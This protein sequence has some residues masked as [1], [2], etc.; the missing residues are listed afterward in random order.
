MLKKHKKYTKPRKKFDLERVKEENEIVKRY[1]LKNKREVW[2]ADAE[3]GRI[4]RRAK[5][6]ITK[7][8]EEKKKF[9]DKLKKIGLKVE[10]IADVL[11]LNLEDLLKRRLQSILS[12]KNKIPMKNARQLIVHKHIS[13]D[14]KILNVPSYI[15]PVIEEDKI[16]IIKSVKLKKEKKPENMVEEIKE[17]AEENKQEEKKEV[18]NK[19]ENKEEKQEVKNG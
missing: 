16:E 19:T 15:V 18:E 11:G 2:K 13:I 8:E 4:R 17:K 5:T 3:I 1:G 12:K 6:L 10:N 7:S 14:G 9:L